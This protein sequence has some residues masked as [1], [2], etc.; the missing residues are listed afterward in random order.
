MAKLERNE[1]YDFTAAATA[2]TLSTGRK[3]IR[4]FSYYRTEKSDRIYSEELH[5]LCIGIRK[6]T[7]S[8]HNLM[9]S[10]ENYS[11]FFVA[12]AGQI[13]DRLEELHRKLLFF[14][15]EEIIGL[16]RLIDGQRTFWNRATDPEFYDEILISHL[17]HDIPEKLLKIELELLRLPD[18]AA[19]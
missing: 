1:L 11:P 18:S 9:T 6:D 17:E 2:L 4:N 16:I 3:L 5:A 10:S 12:I 15:P 19:L 14:D 13:S 7:F 8:L